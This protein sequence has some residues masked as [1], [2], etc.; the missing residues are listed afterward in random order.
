MARPRF[1][2]VPVKTKC[3]KLIRCLLSGFVICVCHISSKHKPYIARYYNMYNL[4]T[5][6]TF[7]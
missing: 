1:D 7:T 2:I 5:A 4:S 6:G 3:L